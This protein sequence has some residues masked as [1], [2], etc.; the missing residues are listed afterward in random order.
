MTPIDHIVQFLRCETPDDWIATALENPAL[1]LIDHA[2]CE[3]KAASTAMNLMYR[4]VDDFELLNKMSRLAREEL[5]HFEQ[6]IALM[7]K[8][9]IDYRQISASRYAAE[10]RKSVRSTEPG[11]LID[12]LIVGAVIEA[13][14]CERF[15]KLAPHL[16]EE[17]KTFYLSLLKSEARH[18]QDYL[19]LAEKVA[20]GESI[21]ARI[22]T[23][24]AVEQS[25][26][27]QGDREFRF[28]SGPLVCDRVCE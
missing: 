5:R 9:G 6:V 19:G 25:L 20:A 4:Y 17:L 28:H 8:R 12:T 16:D 15:A 18:Y 13:R 1:L 10:L 24:L 2:N 21:A 27:L 7:E 26:V 3:K 23:F 14:S 11:R 22:D